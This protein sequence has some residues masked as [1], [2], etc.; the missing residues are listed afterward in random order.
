MP[1]D[2]AIKDIDLHRVKLL[3]VDTEGF[4]ARI[5]RGSQNVLKIGRPIVIFEYNR[6]TLSPL[7]E[8]GLSWG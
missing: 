7:G 5:L 6:E 4:E 2:D 3:K 1:L 8:D